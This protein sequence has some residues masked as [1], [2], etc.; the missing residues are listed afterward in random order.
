MANKIVLLILV[1]LN[2]MVGNLI[3]KSIKADIDYTS[4]VLEIDR[5]VIERLQDV[6][7]A[8]AAF[9]DMKGYFAGTFDS[10]RMFLTQEKYVKIRKIG[11]LDSDSLSGL[12]IDTLYVDP[13]KEFFPPDFNPQ[14]LGLVPPHDTALFILKTDFIEKN[15]ILMPVYQVTDPYPYNKNRTLQVGSLTDAVY[16]G[17]WK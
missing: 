4:N 6:Q 5:A 1:V 10:L 8:Q 14:T 2:L 3:Y 11:D 16:S 17:N 13:I 9:R 15:Y 7:K 12:S